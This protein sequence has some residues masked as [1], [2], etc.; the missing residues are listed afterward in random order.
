[1]TDAFCGIESSSR[2][3]LELAFDGPNFCWLHREQS[4]E[5]WT[6]N[7]PSRRSV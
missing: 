2:E 7:E 4:N 3:I 6:D 1:M 5:L